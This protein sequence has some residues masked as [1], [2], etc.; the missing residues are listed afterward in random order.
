MILEATTDFWG[1]VWL[2]PDALPAAPEFGEA[3]KA[4]LNLWKERGLRVAW[5]KVPLEQSPIIPIAVTTGFRFHH[6]SED[7]LMLT[8]RLQE[9]AFILPFASHYVGAG[10]A[11]LNERGELLV[12]LEL[13]HAKTR[14]KA[15]K[16]PGG[17]LEPGEAITKGVMREV[18]EE[19]GVR[20]HFKSLVCFGH[21]QGYHFGKSTLYFVCRLEP[22]T[23][24]ITV[25]ASEIAEA[26]W[27]PAEEFLESKHINEFEKRIVRAALGRE[28]MAASS[29]ESDRDLPAIPEIFALSGF[30]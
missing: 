1:G 23:Q 11:V 3:L 17:L 21:M 20:T 14:P 22:L 2:L 9:G 25:D 24:E 29:L 19:T 12:V 16:L 15:Y 26:L 30:K 4:S 6:S 8:L 28:G 5:L 13:Y 10:G 18:F 27:M 7:Y